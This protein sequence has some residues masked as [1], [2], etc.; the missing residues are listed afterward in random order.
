MW[1]SFNLTPLL[2]W[3]R[4]S[5]IFALSHSNRTERVF[6]VWSAFPFL[7]FI[8]WTKKTKKCLNS[9]HSCGKK[10][11]L[12]FGF[13]VSSQVKATLRL[14]YGIFW[15]DVVYSFTF[16]MSNHLNSLGFIVLIITIPT[17]KENSTKNLDSN[18]L[19][20]S[21]KNVYFFLLVQQQLHSSLKFCRFDTRSTL[22]SYWM[23]TI[24]GVR[25][26]QPTSERFVAF[27]IHWNMNCQTQRCLNI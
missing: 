17:Q 7:Y 4:R 10:R 13:E 5:V 25:D 2:N 8:Y 15:Y 27:F 6:A 12:T 9:N 1:I 3:H 26:C 11:N 24:C 23:A 18:G 14:F 21:Y 22:G 16:P 19:L 20:I